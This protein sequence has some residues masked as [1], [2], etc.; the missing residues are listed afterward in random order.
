MWQ[1]LLNL[2]RERG[3]KLL[4]NMMWIKNV[5]TSI[6]SHPWQ[7]PVPSSAGLYAGTLYAVRMR[8]FLPADLFAIFSNS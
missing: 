4:K 1:L 8:H 7:W 6:V 3:K 5:K 2:Q